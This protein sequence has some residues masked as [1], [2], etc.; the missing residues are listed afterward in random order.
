MENA[1][2]RNIDEII[3]RLPA[4]RRAAVMKKSRSI[5]EKAL[6]SQARRNAAAAGKQEL[7]DAAQSPKKTPGAS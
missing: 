7:R 3:N 6:R 2:A 4:K 5:V 1:V